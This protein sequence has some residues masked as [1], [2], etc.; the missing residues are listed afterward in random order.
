M[1]A[2][3]AGITMAGE[4]P[5]P[6]KIFSET[7]GDVTDKIILSVIE[8]DRI[9]AAFYPWIDGYSPKGH[10]E[11]REQERWHHWET[12]QRKSDRRW[13]LIELLV[14]IGAGAITAIV[15]A[16]IERGSWF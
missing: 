6:F 4:A 12:D 7:A 2:E 9:C 1:E 16:M 11:M 13:R 8:K 14:F 10:H 15:A 5:G 3:G